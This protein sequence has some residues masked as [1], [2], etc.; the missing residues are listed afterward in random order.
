VNLAARN[1]GG[2]PA[3][4]RRRAHPPTRLLDEEQARLIEILLAAGGRPVSYDEL[5]DRGVENPAT[6]CY[7][8]EIAGLPVTLVRRPR[9]GGQ[10][11]SLGVRLGEE[12]LED[13]ALAELT[14]IAPEEAPGRTASAAALRHTLAARG[15]LAA[16]RSLAAMRRLAPAGAGVR[17]GALAASLA[18]RWRGEGPHR[19]QSDP[20]AGARGNGNARIGFAIV[21]IVCTAALAAALAAISGGSGGGRT[22]GYAS[23]RGVAGAIHG[24]AAGAATG[25]HAGRIG[26]GRGPAGGHNGAHRTAAALPP[27]EAT[28]AAHL[29]SEGHRL[30]EEGSYAAAAEDEQAAVRASGQ[31]AS[32]CAEPVTEACL[33]YAY[34]LYDLARALQAEHDPAAAVPVLR[35]RLLIDNQRATVRAALLEARAQLRRRTHRGRGARARQR[36]RDRPWASR[37]GTRRPAPGAG[38]GEGPSGMSGPRS[39][40][41]G[42]GT[43]GGP[44]G[45]G[46]GEAREGARPA[47]GA[48]GAGETGRNGGDEGVG[49]TGGEAAGAGRTGPTPEG[50]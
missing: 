6:L 45:A 12:L 48:R 23:L 34:A 29:Q 49:A 50:A 27:G 44:T 39:A 21:A 17:L 24:G 25:A 26:A 8:L 10:P 43:R 19:W 46:G 14:G 4:H 13:P 15:S 11:V 47:P 40:P 35:K 9:L 28:G 31:S 37:P 32:G 7:E 42:G 16:A 1:G 30:L 2:P 3:R 33:T 36:H 5:R 22:A 18:E 41:E 38:G 20:G